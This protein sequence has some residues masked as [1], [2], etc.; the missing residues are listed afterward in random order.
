MKHFDKIWRVRE[1]DPAIV[2][3]LASETASSEV[4]AR[5]LAGRGFQDSQEVG[6][7]LNPSL[8]NL[9]DPF[10]MKGMAE[11][12]TRIRIA[13]DR[14]EKIWIYGDYDV[15]GITAISLLSR[16]FSWLDYPVGYYIPD[17]LEEGYGISEAGVSRLR[18][19]GCN[20]M[21]SVDCGI[22][23][24][25]RALQAKAL[26]M[27]VIIT[28]HHEP[29]EIRPDAVAVINPKQEDCS[30][31]EKALSG[32]GIA[33][34]LA[35]A[36]APHFLAE[37]VAAEL[38]QIAALGTVAD[39]VPLTGENRIL[40]K[41]GIDAL[42]KAPVIGTAALMKASGVDPARVSTGQIGFMLAPRINAAGR[43]DQPQKG[44]ELLITG[45]P[46]EAAGLSEELSAL[47]EERQRIEKQIFEEAL[48]ALQRQTDFQSQRVLVVAGEG[49]HPGVIGIVASRIVER[50]YRP[51]IL[52]NLDAGIAKGSARSIEG[53][54]LFE[55]LCTAQQLLS[56]F[57]GH[58]MAAGMTLPAEHV[59]ALRDGLNRY[60]QEALTEEDLIPRIHADCTLD[61]RQLQFS[62][63]DDLDT[64]E[65]FGP[66]NPKP[67]FLYRGLTIDQ[68]RLMGKNQEHVKLITH[69]GNRIFE[70]IGFRWPEPGRFAP[71]QQVDLAFVLERNTF[72]GV[73]SL[74]L[75]MRDSRIRQWG[76]YKHQRMFREYWASY[77]RAC[78]SL[79]AFLKTPE[80]G[81][82]DH[83]P[84]GLIEQTDLAE[85]PSGN[86]EGSL[87]ILLWTPTALE[88]LLAQQQDIN[89]AARIPICFGHCPQSL[90]R[91]VVVNPD[92]ADLQ[93]DEADTLLLWERPPLK[94][95]YG[96]GR[97]AC[98]NT[99]ILYNN[100]VDDGM[101][102]ILDMLVPSKDALAATY[103]EIRKSGGQCWRRSRYQDPSQDPLEVLKEEVRLWILTENGLLARDPHDDGILYSLSPYS[104]E[105]LN[106]VDSESYRFLM[107]L[108][109]A[110]IR[111][112]L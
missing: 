64:L 94:T 4:L 85:L 74:Q 82:S 56:K 93:L 41:H 50:F 66:G 73:E 17:R 46:E 15:D 84:W 103:R 33:F 14:H 105:R 96:W 98:K 13:M 86:A 8:D 52:L 3:R 19:L 68:R 45:N 32:V 12:V 23:A 54:N 43:I 10:L 25:D 70:A 53:F 31:P 9:L 101:V 49:W 81:C 83:A 44:V 40:V 99:G 76:F 97:S 1:A 11:A 48:Q 34:K 16:F 106:I 59:N 111:Y 21:I 42:R 91:A 104:G 28:D 51:C 57:G 79:A 72:N 107:A 58:E 89:P 71:G 61:A 39:I 7:F 92:F 47:N 90:R 60:A 87:R 108:K 62:L 5:I 75:Q 77:W 20:L 65:P 22:T 63:L 102:G 26:G 24:V 37:P 95:V 29:Q 69:D 2:A 35:Q 36:L 112:T 6:A 30:Y 18:E 38:L 27:D 67:V 55:A 80:A 110:I 100:T 78:S 88:S 109:S